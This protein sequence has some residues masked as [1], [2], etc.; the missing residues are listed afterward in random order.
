[1]NE[2]ALCLIWA[3]AEVKRQL[4]KLVGSGRAYKLRG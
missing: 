1:M 4:T 3:M 2:D